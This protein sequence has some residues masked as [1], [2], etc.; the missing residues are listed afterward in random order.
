[1]EDIPGQGIG[2]VELR[3]SAWTAQNL[4]TEPIP[5]STR[6]RVEKVDGLTL[7]IRA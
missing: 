2:K 3:G 5:R 6:V 7:F 1:M 4:G